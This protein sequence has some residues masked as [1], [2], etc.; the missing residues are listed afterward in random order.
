MPPVASVER[1][2]QEWKVGGYPLFI[3]ANAVADEI[4]NIVRAACRA[5]DNVGDIV[6]GPASIRKARRVWCRSASR[7]MRKGAEALDFGWR[8]RRHRH[9]ETQQLGKRPDFR[10]GI[11]PFILQQQF[12]DVFARI[13]RPELATTFL[14]ELESPVYIPHRTEASA[15]EA[16]SSSSGA[17]HGDHDEGA[18]SG[19][20]TPR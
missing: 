9:V 6:V 11:L 2:R 7:V 20:T 10:I 1:C 16:A 13:G 12:Y 15:P 18:A 14:M 8:C 4:G 3:D 17:D 19:K 5:H